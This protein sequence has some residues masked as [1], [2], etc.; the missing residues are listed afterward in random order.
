M[1][2]LV[3]LGTTTALAGE[4]GQ[5]KWT[6]ET[7]YGGIRSSPAIGDD[8]TVYIGSD[9]EKV[10]ALNG[11]TGKMRWSFT[12]GGMVRS[13][14]AIGDDGTVYVGSV[15]SKVYALNGGTGTKKWSF[16]TGD[17]VFSSPA[18]GADGTVYI[19]S[20]DK[21]VYALH[22][23]TGAM[24]WSYATGAA[25]E[26]SPA[27]G[28]DGTVYIG[29]YDRN[30]YALDGTTGAKKWSYA[31]ANAVIYSPA[32]GA[33]GTVYL[34]GAINDQ[35]IYALDGSTGVKEWS[36]PAPTPGFST[37]T[38]IGTDG[39]LY[40]TYYNDLY[41]LEGTTGAQK[42]VHPL[43]FQT[44]STGWTYASPTVCSDGTMYLGGL[45]SMFCIEG[46]TGAEKWRREI[47]DNWGL[48]YER[49]SSP[50][51]GA[52]GTIY[53]G[54]YAD[55]FF[56]P[57]PG[58]VYALYGSSGLAKTPWP[59]FRGNA[60]NDGRLVLSLPTFQ[61]PARVILNEG[62]PG[63]ISAKVKGVP[64][65][66]LLWL[67]NGLPVVGSA[68]ATLT[69]ASVT[70]AHEGV[71]ALVASNAVGQ[72]TSKPII[73]VVSNIRPQQWM[74]LDWEGGTEG[75]VSLEYASQLGTSTQWHSVS[76]L[77]SVGTRMTYVEMDP[78]SPTRFYRL[79]SAAATPIRSAGLVNGWTIT[80]PIGSRIRVEVVTE[81][82]GW[83]NWQ[84]LTNLTLPASPYLFLDLESLAAP[85]R[86]YRTTLQP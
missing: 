79:H 45:G 20:N 53:F 37:P 4:P 9:D 62:S 70:R 73:A 10:Y 13:S 60:R 81:A 30:L 7:P 2:V 55:G 44:G 77:T 38:T 52:D 35:S 75:S 47:C 57:T 82:N 78:S 15:D 72:A 32:I 3:M 85:E 51:I 33:D 46:T 80:E 58:K 71:Y 54:S 68:Q 86:V 83:T 24:R 31:I 41:A 22:G 14:P 43:S 48:E 17:S 39:T 59:K 76:N 49:P 40:A 74:G 25:V 34:V 21:K 84:V 36:R 67:R 50:T 8:G 42:W 11:A 65:P 1:L 5:L 19:G 56:L 63:R 18:I 6:F 28:A 29:S 66:N 61:Q 69:I 16:S 23:A 27:V 12:T 64:T 26:S